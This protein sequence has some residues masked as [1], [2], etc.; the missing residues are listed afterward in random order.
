MKV[1]R[2]TTSPFKDDISGE[3]AKQF[4]S[5]W[6][7]KGVAVLYTAEHIS[8][9]I[10][11][12]LVHLQFKE[13]PADY[14]LLQLNVPDTITATE[15]DAAKLKQHWQDDPSY[16][17]FIGNE[18]FHSMKSALLKVPSAV[19]QEEYNLLANPLHPDFKKIKIIKSKAFRFD[20][21]L[22]SLQ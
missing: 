18:F 22:F 8:L 2:I 10:L 5:R 4:G 20:N 21:R 9:A 14:W 6:N 7:T 11:E 19:V 17:Q 15:I 16:T 1:F 3:G 13:V 12:M